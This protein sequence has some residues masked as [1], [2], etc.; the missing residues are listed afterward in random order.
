MDRELSC[1]INGDTWRVQF[2]EMPADAGGSF[3]QCEEQTTGQ[4]LTLSGE[5][6]QNLIP[7]VLREVLAQRKLMHRELCRDIFKVVGLP[8]FDQWVDRVNSFMDRMEPDY[9]QLHFESDGP[10]DPAIE[11][12][13]DDDED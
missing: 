12:P 10:Y 13:F 6:P 9:T 4:V 7:L 1:T 2:Y 11:G 8:Q 5:F 3:W